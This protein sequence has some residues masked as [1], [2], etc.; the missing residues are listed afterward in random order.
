VRLGGGFAGGGVALAVGGFTV[1][2]EDY[3]PSEASPAGDY[4]LTNVRFVDNRFSTVHFE[5]V[6]SYGIWYTRGAPSD[7]WR[8]TGNV[9]VET[10]ENVDTQ[11]PHT[12]AGVLCR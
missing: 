10:G 3:S 12:R 4:S 6:G 5:C 8:R 1:Y 11:N 2:A 7:A 9:V